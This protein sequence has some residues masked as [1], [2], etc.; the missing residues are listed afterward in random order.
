MTNCLF[1][2]CSHGCFLNKLADVSKIL[3][4]IIVP[5]LLILKQLMFIII[6]NKYLHV[7]TGWRTPYSFL[8]IPL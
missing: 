3:T 4:M 6:A 1:S 7:H 8:K 5:F 2:A